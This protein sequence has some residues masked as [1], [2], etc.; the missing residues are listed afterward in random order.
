MKKILLTM[1]I[2]GLTAAPAFAD[3]ITNTPN[4]QTQTQIIKVVGAN[5][6][7]NRVNLNAVGQQ[8]VDQNY[9]TMTLSYTANGNDSKSTQQ[10]LTQKISA[11][12]KQAK[13][14]EDGDKL[15]VK[16]G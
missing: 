5:D 4:N 3:E 6:V 13:T 7:Q 10:E 15:K 8:D 12:I 9:L 14:H 11:A 2:S 1:I 16:S